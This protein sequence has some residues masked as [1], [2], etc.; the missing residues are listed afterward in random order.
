[1]KRVVVI[2]E[3]SNQVQ[4]F[5]EVLLRDKKK[6]SNGKKQLIQGTWNRSDISYSLTFLPLIGHITEITHAPG[7]GWYECLPIQVVEEEEALTILENHEYVKIIT[8]LVQ[9]AEEIWLATDPDSEGDNIAYEALQ[10][11]LRAKPGL[12]VKRIWNASLTKKEILRAFENPTG[13]NNNLA[14]AVTGRRMTDAWMGFAGTRELTR[15][16]KRAGR[17]RV[18]SVG[19]VQLPL[20]KLIVDRDRE[21]ANFQPEDRWNLLAHLKCNTEGII[22]EHK[23]NPFEKEDEMKNHFVKASSTSTAI[24][25]KRATK[26]VQ[27]AP[28]QPLNTTSAIA[29]ICRLTPLRAQGALNA[30]SALYQ[31]G[32]LSYPRTDNTRFVDEFPHQ[33]ILN[34]LSRDSSWKLLISKITN[35]S[36][37]RVNGKKRGVEDHDPIHPTGELPSSD[38][39]EALSSTHLKVWKIITSYYIGLFLEDEETQREYVSFKLNSEP[40]VV[41]GITI[42]KS[43]WTETHTWAASKPNPLPQ[44][45][46]GQS[47]PIQEIEIKT[48]QTKPRPRWSDTSLIKELENL[49]IG[50]KSSRP[51]ILQKLVQRKYLKREKKAIE[52]TEYGQDLI[53]MLEPIWEDV[54]SPN[55]TRHVEELMESVAEGQSSYDSMIQEIREEYLLLHKKLIK[56][57]PS[58]VSSLKTK[59][60]QMSRRIKKLQERDFGSCPICETGTITP[61]GIP[62][63]QEIFLG[64]SNF[65]KC[66]WSSPLPDDLSLEDLDEPDDKMESSTETSSQEKSLLN[67][68]SKLSI[69][70]L[71]HVQEKPTLKPLSSRDDYIGPCNMPNCFGELI[72]HESIND[73]PTVHCTDC[74]TAYGLPLG[75]KTEIREEKCSDCGN[76]IVLALRPNKKV[77]YICPTCKKYLREG[78][79][80]SRSINSKN[81]V[82]ET[83]VSPSAAPKRVSV[84]SDYGLSIGSCYTENCIGQL[85]L[86]DLPNG[87]TGVQ[88]TECRTLYY[89]LPIGAKVEI[90]SEICPNCNHNTILAFQPNRKTYRICAYCKKYCNSCK[91]KECHLKN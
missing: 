74:Q 81:Q 30:L 33:D 2:G 75:G 21:R 72:L 80:I 10:I 91:N 27:R 90:T 36:Q 26:V 5:A 69:D 54:L 68:R 73:R 79:S 50:T 63:T 16:V 32:L 42:L 59:Q 8:E 66:K 38:S 49:N 29:L 12:T 85:V 43:G 44:L 14:L 41:R 37:V 48:F 40:F 88:C 62:E 67:E 77:Y 18:S 1:M 15:A 4:K 89:T 83:T 7:Y 87:R 46:V 39:G 3:K 17:K 71:S 31:E 34:A 58:L 52:S 70:R 23:L 82:T 11:A 24:V 19:R 22:A 6:L 20:L 86:Q 47:L 78:T 60:E 64:C 84:S 13:W 65:P 45:S 55:F 53:E 56:Q 35:T 61:R 28:P 25:R 9:E 76:H 51:T 57:L